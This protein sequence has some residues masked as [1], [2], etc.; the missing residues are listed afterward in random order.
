MIGT[1]ALAPHLIRVHAKVRPIRE[2]AIWGRRPEAGRGAGAGARSFP[3]GRARPA[4]DGAGRRRPQGGGGRGRHRVLRDAVEG[5]AGRRRLAARGP[6]YRSGRRLH[7]RDARKR[8][9]GGVARAGLC[10]YARRRAKEG[11]RHRP[12]AAQRHDRRGR[13]D[14]RPVRAGAGP[15]DR[16]AARRHG[17]HHALQVGGR[18][19]RGPCGSRTRGGA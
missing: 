11:G 16:P 17:Q 10:R 8:R 18:R 6:A 14:R 15:A 13:R 4:V 7:P 1:G 12:A 19:A 5:A 9:Q 3:A 2:V